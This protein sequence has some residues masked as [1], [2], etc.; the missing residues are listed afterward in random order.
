M[1]WETCARIHNDVTVNMLPWQDSGLLFTFTTQH[2]PS[3]WLFITGVQWMAFNRYSK[4]RKCHR[5]SQAS[6]HSREVNKVKETAL[7]WRK[8]VILCSLRFYAHTWL[9]FA[10]NSLNADQSFLPNSPFLP[11]LQ[12]PRLMT[13]P[14][15]A[16][17]TSP[18]ENCTAGV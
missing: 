5:L 16:V 18:L 6:V 1:S 2:V 8:A 11:N 9:V 4:Q 17:E 10:E 3:A 13:Q 15:E 14:S 7:C 12:A